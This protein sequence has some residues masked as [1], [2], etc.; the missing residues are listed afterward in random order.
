L[1]FGWSRI[2]PS[3]LH[4]G[5]SILPVVLLV[6]LFRSFIHSFNNDYIIAVWV[7]FLS[8]IYIFLIFVLGRFFSSGPKN[9]LA[10]IIS[11]LNRS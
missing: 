7:V 10:V 3:L 4:I 6:I 8:L 5:F 1:Q 2:L 9:T 11:E